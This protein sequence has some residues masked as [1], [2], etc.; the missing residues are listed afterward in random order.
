MSSNTEGEDGI[1]ER[2]FSMQSMAS[3]R[4]VPED[5]DEVENCIVCMEAFNDT[6]HRP[7]C[8]P[9]E[10]RDGQPP[11]RHCVVCRYCFE[12]EFLPRLQQGSLTCP[13]C[14]QVFRNPIEIQDAFQRDCL[15]YPPDRPYTKHYIKSSEWTESDDKRDCLNRM[16]TAQP[17]RMSDGPS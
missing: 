15:E 11:G 12:T 1:G 8:L 16:A 6:D 13:K 7:V 17:V 3:S 4:I 14:R 9:C 10:I 5:E 2:T